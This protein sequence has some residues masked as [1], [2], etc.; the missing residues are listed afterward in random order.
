MNQIHLLI[1]KLFSPLKRW[2]KDFAFTPKSPVLSALLANSHMQKT[3]SNS[4]EWT[5]FNKLGLDNQ[6]ELPFAHYR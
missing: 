1:P 5:L 4:L 6:T 3:E 2:N